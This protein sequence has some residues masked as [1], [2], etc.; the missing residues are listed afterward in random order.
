MSKLNR[1]E[2]VIRLPDDIPWKVPDGAPEQSV[3]DATLAGGEDKTGMKWYP[4]CMSATERAVF[5]VSGIGP[6]DQTWVDSSLPPLRR[7]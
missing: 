6:V 4:G 3:E 5:A 7:I 2:T 1:N